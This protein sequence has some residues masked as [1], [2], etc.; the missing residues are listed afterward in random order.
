[1]NRT[2]L[3][4]LLWLALTA[5]LVL[6]GA[7]LPFAAV[8]LQD[9]AGEERTELRSFEAVQLSLRQELEVGQ[10]LRL[11]SGSVEGSGWNRGG[12]GRRGRGAVPPG[13]S[14]RAAP[15]SPRREWKRRCWASWIRCL[16]RVCSA[17]PPR[18]GRGRCAAI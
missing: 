10:V 9:A 14:G 15:A 16:R 3:Q 12:A 8:W 6:T 2:L 7:A 18:T 1:M 11:L 5:L 17:S 4:R 13:L